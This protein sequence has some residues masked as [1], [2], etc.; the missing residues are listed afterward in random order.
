MSKLTQDHSTDGTLKD[1]PPKPPLV[2]RKQ[3]VELIRAELG[4]PLGL[5]KIEK[6]AM[7]GCGPRPRARY[8]RHFLYDRDD[9]LAYGRSLIEPVAG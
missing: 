6:D 7:D 2:T 8:G 3:A 4:V 5:S 9:V 1:A